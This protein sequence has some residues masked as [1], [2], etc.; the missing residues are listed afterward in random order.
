MTNN[1]ERWE[2]ND[3]SF[4]KIFVEI[5]EL[6]STENKSKRDKSSAHVRLLK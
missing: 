6:N 2:S 4:C 3:P 5:L 1:L